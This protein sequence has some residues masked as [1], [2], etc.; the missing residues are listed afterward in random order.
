MKSRVIEKPSTN[1]CT[2]EF[3]CSSSN[4]MTVEGEKV[5]HCATIRGYLLC[6]YVKLSRG[7]SSRGVRNRVK[8]WHSDSALVTLEQQ[9]KPR[10]C[11]C[12]RKRQ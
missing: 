3:D 6:G 1:T 12:K 11:L 5:S 7:G 4:R 9:E 10:E 8:S 2:G